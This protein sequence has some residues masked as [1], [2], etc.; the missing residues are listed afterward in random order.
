MMANLRRRGVRKP[1]WAIALV[2]AGSAAAACRARAPEPPADV[3][4]LNAR[5]YTLGWDEPAPDGTPAA[6]A[7]YAPATGWHP[8]AEAVAVRDGR[9]VFVGGA[10]EAERYRASAREVVDLGG[11]TLLPGLVD[12][13]VHIAELGASLE[14]VDLVGVTSEEEAIARV[15]AR[16]RTTPKGQW[17]VGWGWDE[18]AWA[19]R[20]PDMTALSRRVPDHPVILRGL[21]GFAVWGN[22]LAFERAG[23]TRATPSPPGGE[24]RRDARGEPT[25][26][27]LNAARALLERAIPEPTPAELEAQVLAGLTAMARA[28]FVAVHEAGADSR[29]V[30][31]LEDLHA[32][33]RLPIRVSVM[34][35]AR[36]PGLLRLWL[37]RGPTRD[38]GGWLTIRS[39]KVFA[40]GALGSRGA[41]L[42]AD[43]ADRPGHRGVPARDVDRALVGAMMAKGFQVCIHAIGDAANRDALDFIEAVERAQP[44]ARLGR[45][46]IE[47]AQVIH[48]DDFPRFAALGVIA[49]MQPGHAVEDKAWAEDRLGPDRIAG[50]YA[51]RRVRGAGARLVLSSDLPG[52]SYD[53]FYELH[54]AV[55]RRDR[56]LE[57]PG[58]WYPHERLTPEEAL[59]GYTTWAAFAGFEEQEAGVIAPGR[60]ADLTAMDLDP[61]VVGTTAPDR[62]LR[63]TIRLT[64]VGGRIRYRAP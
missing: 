33:G 47:H 4:F 13:H 27:L 2:L 52:S 56:D 37:A 53:I 10:R 50:A 40:D 59:R 42:L 23:I 8:D 38:P 1:W 11:A 55:T 35:S 46:R 30:D 39:V 62:L 22:R 24:I 29:L 60:R 7:P 21:H 64:M 51:W 63:G 36:D 17:I 20:Y 9:I 34:L 54:A 49:S 44:S 19:N 25:G 45:H 61:L 6:N 41:W 26:V 3:L 12:A 57:P 15:A 18:G 5:V 32:A 14:R 48:P 43:Y 28:G 16:A 58:G 31:V